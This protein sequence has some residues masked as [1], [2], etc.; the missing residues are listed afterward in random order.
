MELDKQQ[1]EDRNEDQVPH[2]QNPARA[3]ACDQVEGPQS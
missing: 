3:P 2:E 1:T